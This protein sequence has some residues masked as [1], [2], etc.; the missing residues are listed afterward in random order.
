M[1]IDTNFNFTLNHSTIPEGPIV[2]WLV[3]C[4]CIR[5][6]IKQGI[7]HLSVVV[8]WK[9]IS[10][11]AIRRST[12]KIFSHSTCWSSY[13]LGQKIDQTTVFTRC[14]IN[15]FVVVNLCAVWLQS[16]NR[17]FLSSHFLSYVQ[18]TST[19]CLLSNLISYNR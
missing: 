1:F 14:L 9:E 8:Q 15:V 11:E 16:N 5:R 7:Y 2:F 4:F 19:E 18:P 10:L 12:S 13:A 6:Y 3:S 17:D